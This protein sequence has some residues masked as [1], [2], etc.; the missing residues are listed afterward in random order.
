MKKL[1]LLA[2][3]LLLT[4]G[5]ASATI[6]WAGNQWPLHDSNHTPTGPIAVYAQVYKTG[7]TDAAG[8]GAELWGELYYASSTDGLYH[9]A[10]MTFNGDI[11]N[12]DEYTGEIPQ[13]ALI[14]ATWVDSYV[15]FHDDSDGTVAWITGDQ[16]GNPPPL[17][18]NV[19][20]VLPVDVTVSFTM[21][22]S[23]A[24]SSGD[25]CVIGSANEL[26]TWAN[27]VTM[28]TGD[29]E[30]WEIDIVFA[31]GG[32]PSFE[33]KY[34]KD[35]CSTWESVGNRLVTLP[36]DG[37]TSVVLAVDSWDDQPLGC[38]T[39]A[40]EAESWDGVKARYR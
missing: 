6:D 37:T 10:P 24:G 33:Y 14:G 23:G 34:R 27:G 5:S 12:N 7:V 3:C 38:G 21:C 40:A 4:A 28:T 17:R 15:I 36:T 8:Q 35:G 2:A 20:D 39:V 22:L 13:S 29:G 1:L 11:G 30:L 31:A 25:A 26:G 9:I 16:S 19:I 32:N 18:Y